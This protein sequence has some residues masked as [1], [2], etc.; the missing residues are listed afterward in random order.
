MKIPGTRTLSCLKSIT[1]PSSTIAPS[2]ATLGK[3]N[4]KFEKTKN[5]EFG[6][7]LLSAETNKAKYK[8]EIANAIN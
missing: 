2:I 3:G 8:L 7:L 5:L 4:D 6:H 1:K